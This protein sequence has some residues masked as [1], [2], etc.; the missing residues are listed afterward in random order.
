MKKILSTALFL[1]LCTS[2]LFFPQN[3]V[4]I[5]TY[6][7][8]N[9][10]NSENDSRNIYYKKIV[11]AVKPDILVLQE[12]KTA[13]SVSQFLS[14]ALNSKYNAGTFIPNQATNETNNALFYKD[15]LF[16]F[17]ANYPVVITPN[18][19]QTERDISEFKLVHNFS[20]D[21][22]IIYS[23]HLKS[24]P[25]A[26]NEQRRLKEV[27]TLLGRTSKLSSK[28]YYMIVGDFNLY[29]SLE[30]AYIKLTDAESPGYFVDPT[31]ITGVFNNRDY[32]AHHTQSTRWPNLPDGG[33]NGGLDDRFDFLLISPS[34]MGNSKV[35]IV[36]GSYTAFGNDGQHYDRSI[37]DA[38]NSAVGQEIAD[39]LYYG[40]DHLPVY[41]DFHFGISSSVSG[42]PCIANEFVLFQ[43]YPNPFNPS[44]TISYQLPSSNWV[45]L[46]VFD[47]LGR[48][49]TTLVNE[50]KLAG[51]YNC[52]LRIDNGELSSG[53]YF[54]KITASNFS[55]SA[56]MLLLK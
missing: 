23:A 6:N 31:P 52:E 38:G 4:R 45:T 26:D 7:I 48:E 11:T 10:T 53:I 41:A 27:T 29:S 39:A 36:N 20:K 21:T 50:Y 5:M 9:Y 37:N 51:K 19:G 30:P 1:L 18:P 56:K 35:K 42:D 47:L 46:K 24:S 22:I 49:V 44:T 34:L 2:Q 43:N 17:I 55:K 25:G 8:L 16:T 28:S 14:R 15:S 40:S 33:A 32:S 12:V 13:S 54:Y 3:K